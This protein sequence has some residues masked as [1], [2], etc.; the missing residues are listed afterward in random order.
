VIQITTLDRRWIEARDTG[1][2][3][4]LRVRV[5]VDRDRLV[6]GAGLAGTMVLAWLG[7]PWWIPLG[8]L[9]VRGLPGPLASAATAVLVYSVWPTWWL[10]LPVVALL[11]GLRIRVR[12]GRG[13]YRSVNPWAEGLRPVRAAATAA[14]S[15]FLSRTPG[16]VQVDSGFLVTLATV[17]GAAVTAWRGGPWWIPLSSIAVMGLPVFLA[18]PLA[19]VL[20]WLAWPTWWMAVPVIALLSGIT[21]RSRW[22]PSNARARGLRALEA[23]VRTG[24]L[25]HLHQSVR[26]LGRAAATVEPGHPDR[27]VYVGNYVTALV[28]KYDRVGGSELL[29]L[30]ERLIREALAAVPDG[31]RHRSLGL[32]GLSEV[33][34]ARYRSTGDRAQLE[35][36]VQL[37]RAAVTS[38]HDDDQSAAL[39]TN[40]GV[41]LLH[42]YQQDRDP[43]IL[44]EAVAAGRDA[45]AALPP[46]SLYGFGMLS[47][48][49]TTLLASYAVSGELAVLEEAVETGRRV[50]A[51][52]RHTGT[53][54]DGHLVNLA[55]TLIVLFQR[56]RQPALLDEAIT[57]TREAVAGS[58]HGHPERASFVSALGRVL[59]MAAEHGDRPALA[60]EAVRTFREALA[61]GSGNTAARRERLDDLCA[62]LVTSFAAHGRPD[63][64]A[65]AVDAGRAALALVPPADPER[66]FT[67]LRLG[68]A[69]EQRYDHD[70]DPAI[71]A[72]CCRTY[73]AAAEN[74][75][76][77]GH[78][79]GRGALRAAEAYLRAGD[80]DAALAMVELGVGQLPRIAP[81]Q[82]TFDDRV[83]HAVT[84][85][86]LAATAAETAIRAGRPGRAVE[87]LEQ[88]RG[89]TLGGL[90]DR[91]GDPTVLRSRAPHL[92]T[93]L[94]ELTRAIEDADA[95]PPPALA[96][97]PHEPPSGEALGRL[98]TEL[99]RSWDDLM[100]R[101]RAHPGLHDFLLPPPIERLREQAGPG[102]IVYVVAH[103]DHG[104]ALII[105]SDIEEPVTVVNLPLLSRPAVDDRVAELHRAQRSATGPGTAAER[106][107]AQQDVLRVLE[108]L[109]EA[110]A[111]PILVALG[112]TGPPA[113]GEPWPRLWWCP[114]GPCALLPLHAAGH[115]AAGEGETV[116]DRVVSSYTTTVRTLAH[117]RRAGPGRRR[118]VSTLVVSVPDAPGATPL[119]GATGEAE[120]V[121][122]LL[123]ATTVLRSPGHDAVTAALPRHT[124]THFAC[125]GVADLLS[126]TESRLLLR[127]HLDHPLTVTAISGLRLDRG[128]LA[129][130]SA[131][132][133]THTAVDHADEAV[134]LTAAFQLAGYFA[135][136]GTLWPVNDRAAVLIAEDFYRHLVRPGHHGPDPTATA[137]A[138]HRAVHLHRARYPGL[139]TQWAAYVHHGL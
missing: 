90:L 28:A 55:S 117:A 93:E 81:R 39:S 108:W 44:T 119:P 24:R 85:A 103:R 123:P 114:V 77:S 98:R 120:L 83:H 3:A 92:A 27:A 54:S 130:L 110:A 135:V 88:A 124:I 5:R 29:D 75:T 72:E 1:D 31:H 129:Y 58:P 12:T 9:V 122:R 84:M 25:H 91:R 131:C 42:L 136:V 89:V 22:L 127:D 47:N 20:I 52:T 80:P 128:E 113:D 95:G 21:N 125:H 15:R 33:L 62:A 53:W 67:L 34:Q 115:H 74:T 32:T 57:L 46:G 134:H 35:E 97:D 118:K 37:C 7:G 45:V 138:L 51:A 30:A 18:L 100:T 116:L 43:Q 76:A 101:I 8:C 133:V 69:L 73:A 59:W 6:A 109:W 104:S 41:A 78:G 79:R 64:L 71:L 68:Q 111:T 102:P 11:S 4:P 139:P 48:L 19:G 13:G 96:G 137:T 61:A 16:R 17:V 86:G 82:L 40:L 106:R 121:A 14:R 60:D 126:P 63:D 112:R 23:Y 132:S 26:F 10:A 38:P 70:G 66:S 2:V 49:Q 65:A 87:L 105:T 107:Q 56:T 94:D 36:G 50:V 99:N